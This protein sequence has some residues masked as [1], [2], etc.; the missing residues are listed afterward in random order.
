MGVEITLFTLPDKCAIVEKTLLAAGNGE[1]LQDICFLVTEIRRGLPA[2]RQTE[3]WTVDEHLTAED[4]EILQDTFQ[5]I[6]QNPHVLFNF[7]YDGPRGHDHVIYLLEL[8]ADSKEKDLPRAAVL[9]SQ[10]TPDS[11]TA[12]QGRPIGWSSVEQAKHI[13]EFLDKVNVDEIA[14]RFEGFPQDLSLIHISEPTRP[15]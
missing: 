2:E 1:L 3:R 8:F 7:L 13:S 15:Y 14:K 12:T 6:Q 9:G 10:G 4:I 11:A 5:S